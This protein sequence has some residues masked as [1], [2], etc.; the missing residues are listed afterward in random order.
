MTSPG[1]MAAHLERDAVLPG[2]RGDEEAE[3]DVV[4]VDGT[5]VGDLQTPGESG[6]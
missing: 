2:A 1:G 5:R 6:R 4:R 3:D